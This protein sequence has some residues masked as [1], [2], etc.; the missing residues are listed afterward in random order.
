MIFQDSFEKIKKNFDLVD[1]HK[2]NQ[3]KINILE[4]VFIIFSILLLILYELVESYYWLKICGGLNLVCDIVFVI[5]LLRLIIPFKN[6]TVSK[7]DVITDVLVAI[8]GLGTIAVLIISLFITKNFHSGEFIAAAGLGIPAFKTTKFLRIFRVIKLFRLM[9]NVKLLK[10][11]SLKSKFCVC[12]QA[13]GW[14]GF[15]LI[16][17]FIIINFIFIM[18]GP[19]ALEEER[20]FQRLNNFKLLVNKTNANTPELLEVVAARYDLKEDIVYISINGTK[21]Y[22]NMYAAYEPK[23]VEQYI[24][25]KF[26][27]LNSSLVTINN[28]KVLFDDKEIF[29]P[30]KINNL[31]WISTI[32]VIMILFSI[33]AAI[34]ISRYFSDMLATVSHQNTD[35]TDLIKKDLNKAIKLVKKICANNPDLLEKIK[36]TIKFNT[37]HI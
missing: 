25:F 6:K 26:C 12:E 17:F 23:I 2:K 29:L 22:F 3:K 14:L 5:L 36:T 4:L 8:P 19:L 37:I 30:D 35:D 16:L 7:L 10:F 13:V 21:T 33:F 11:I 28:I 20:F 24:N 18:T 27:S 1:H 34:L 31:I 32:V 9:R 15:I